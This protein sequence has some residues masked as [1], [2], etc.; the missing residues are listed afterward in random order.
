MPSRKQIIYCRLLH[1]GILYLRAVCSGGGWGTD[2]QVLGTRGEFK[3]CYEVANFLH[4]V[5]GSILEPGYV[6]NDITFINHAFPGYVQQMGTH[7]D[8]GTAALMLEFYDGVPEVMRR[9]LTWHPG[10][11]L[12]RLAGATS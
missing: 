4:R 1:H 7:L 3:I 8:A 2:E 6:D 5:H 9:E 11:A 10:E 12:R